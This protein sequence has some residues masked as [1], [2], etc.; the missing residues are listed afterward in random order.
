MPETELKN[1]FW[2]EGNKHLAV[3]ANQAAVEK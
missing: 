3:P 1:D 2:I